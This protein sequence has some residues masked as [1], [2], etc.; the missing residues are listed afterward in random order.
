LLLKAR[1]QSGV[2]ATARRSM[3]EK[4]IDLNSLSPKR[5]AERRALRITSDIRVSL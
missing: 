2:F 5:P 4:E 1:E 3:L